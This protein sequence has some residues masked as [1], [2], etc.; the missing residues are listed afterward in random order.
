MSFTTAIARWATAQKNV[1]LEAVRSEAPVGKAKQLDLFG[2]VGE[3]QSLATSLKSRA[4][5][6]LGMARIEVS[7]KLHYS[8][9]VKEGH[10]EIRPVN[11]QAL[12][13]V[14]PDT[15][16]DIFRMVSGPVPPNPYP[17]RGWDKVR[18]SVMKDLEKRTVEEGIAQ[19]RS[20]IRKG[21]LF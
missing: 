16:E 11:A 10:A 5:G 14:D 19:L 18:T 8:V 15:G 21:G 2:G 20:T 17:Q 12:H 3:S 6:R 4:I 7:S 9:I 13:W 1:I